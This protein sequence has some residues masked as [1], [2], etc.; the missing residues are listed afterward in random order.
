MNYYPLKI[1]NTYNDAKFINNLIRGTIS[2]KDF[3][4]GIINL[5][6]SYSNNISSTNKEFYKALVSYCSNI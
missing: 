5:S 4:T 2:N 6:I 3:F 1:F